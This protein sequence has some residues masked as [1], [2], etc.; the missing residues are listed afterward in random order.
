MNNKGKSYQE[1]YQEL[2]EIVKE[3]ESDHVSI[4]DMSKKVKRATALAHV[5]KEKLKM[6]EKEVV[7]ILQELESGGESG[8]P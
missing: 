2:V 7:E 8:K 3:L 1:A 6:T 5:C 4:D